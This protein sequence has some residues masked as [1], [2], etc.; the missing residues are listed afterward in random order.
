MTQEVIIPSNP[1]DLKKIKGMIEEAAH[2]FQRIADQN[3]ALKDIL[4]TIKEDFQIAPKY[5]RKMARAYYKNN[6]HD[7]QAEYQEFETL[8]ESVLGNDD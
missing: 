1:A 2:C 7:T 6:F 3:E 8:Y 4:D 5:S